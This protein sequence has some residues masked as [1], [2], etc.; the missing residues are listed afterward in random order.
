MI[1]L[2]KNDCVTCAASPLLTSLYTQSSYK[3]E[4]NLFEMDAECGNLQ[5]Q[6]VGVDSLGVHTDKSGRFR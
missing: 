6:A 2:L 5:I 1:L 3:I 4:E